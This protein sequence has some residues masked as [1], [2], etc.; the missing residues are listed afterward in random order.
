[1]PYVDAKAYLRA[2]NWNELEDEMD[3]LVWNRV[4]TNLWLPERVALS[5][6][7][8]PWRSDL[9]DK[10]RLTTMRV[11]VG[12]TLFDTEQSE[13][14]VEELKKHVITPH[15]DHVLNQFGY[16]ESVHTRTY[17][18]IF[19]TLASTAMITQAY[20]WSYQNDCLQKK[21]RLIKEV[22]ETNDPFKVRIASVFLESFVF[23]SGFYW[24]LYL[25]TRNTMT[26]T[27]TAIKLIIR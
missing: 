4:N 14:G 21:A 20:E 7:K 3:L 17:S 26:Q 15:E 6:D 9:T 5:Q 22:Y 27:G 13:I 1:M 23:Y 25:L 8:T 2:L 16:M 12:L 19:M 10:E 18:S 24:P 11:F